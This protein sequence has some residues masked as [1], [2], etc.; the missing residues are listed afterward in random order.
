MGNRNLQLR[1]YQ[2][3]GARWLAAC[4]RIL[5]DDV[6]VGKTVQAIGAARI[7]RA[8]TIHIVSTKTMLRYWAD[9]LTKWWPNWVEHAEVTFSTY[10][11]LAKYADTKQRWDV[12]ILDEAHKLKNRKTLRRSRVVKVARRCGKVWP[13]TATPIMNRVDE[14]WSL[15]NLVDSTR[16]SSFWKF[17]KMHADAQPG[18]YGWVI[19]PAPTNPSRLAT[20]IAPYFLRRERGVVA[21]DLP[22]V[23]IV[24]Y[25]VPMTPGQA[26]LHHELEQDML[27]TL[28]D[29]TLL[30]AP[31]A[32]A[33]LTR[34]RQCAISPLL[35]ASTE[36]GGKTEAL[37]DLIEGA[38][39]KPVVIFSQWV[40]VLDI[41]ADALAAEGHFI[42]MLHGQLSDKQRDVVQAEWKR[43]DTQILMTTISC[44]GVGL[45]FTHADIAVFTDWAWTP[46][47]NS[48]AIGRLDPTRQPE[49]NRRPVVAYYLVSDDSIEDWTLDKLGNKQAIIDSVLEKLRIHLRR[50]T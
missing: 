24:R 3:D 46:T 33:K 23:E 2:V 36:V 19:N 29:G 13:L 49:D 48:Q 4:N 31:T 17:V 18:R 40:K 15:L 38:E 28:E 42:S 50:T 45:D 43:G 14:L 32:L 11:A 35:F 8:K 37:L 5:G 34:L 27:A 25:R 41:M 7:C 21:N 30:F 10:D 6:G 12:L 22:P 20:D 47:D 39:G 16:W 1:P 9:E 44:G 26:K